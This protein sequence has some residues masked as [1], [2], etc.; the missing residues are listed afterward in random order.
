[1]ARV[2]KIVV[3]LVIFLAAF[4]ITG[5]FIIPPVLKSMLIEKMSEQLHRDVSIERIAL[6]PFRLCLT[7]T[8]FAVREKGKKGTFLS[9]RELFLDLEGMSLFKRAIV[10]DEARLD[11]PYIHLSRYKDGSYNFS[12]LLPAEKPDEKEKDTEPL[13]LSVNNIRIVDGRVTFQDEPM[14]TSHVAEKIQIG[15][16]FL[17]NISRYIDTFVEPSFSA[18]INGT[19]YN[20][21]GRTKPF[22]A[23]RLTEFDIKIKGIDIPHYL[24]YIPGKLNFR[25]V[26][27]FL[28]V[29]TKLTFSQDNE[30]GHQ[31]LLLSGGLSFSKINVDDLQQK[32]LIRIPA[33]N[34]DMASVAPLNGEIK[35]A[36]LFLDSP[37]INVHRTQDGQINLLSLLPPAEEKRRA[38]KKAQE[39]P[40][41]F[42]VD[43][44]AFQLEKGHVNYVDDIPYR[45]FQTTLADIQL[46]GDHLSTAPGREGVISL[47]LALPRNGKLSLEGPA[48][49]SPLSAKLNV[50]LQEMDIADMQPYIRD[51]LKVRVTRGK[52]STQGV[53]EL[54]KPLQELQ[55]RYG[56]KVSINRFACLDAVTASDLLKWNTLYLNGIDFAYQPLSLRIGEIALSNFY[57]RLIIREDGTI[58]LQDLSADNKKAHGGKEAPKEGNKGAQTKTPARKESAPDIRIGAVTLQGGTIDFLDKSIRPKFSA[59]LSAVGG[60]VSGLSSRENTRADVLLRGKLEG[61]APLEIKGKINPLQKDLY[62]DLQALF[63][64][65][66]LSPVTP[67]SGKYLGYEIAKGKLSFDLKYHIDRRKLDSQNII[68]IDQL[69]LGEKVDSPDATKLP[70]SLAISLLKDR[71]GQIKLDIPVAG[72]LD[73]PE[74]SVW[75]I[76]IK[77]ILNLLAKA[78]TAPFALLGS[79]FGGGEEMSYVEFDYGSAL[80]GEENLKKVALLSKALTERPALKIDLEGYVDADQDREALRNITFQRK[81]KKQKLNDLIRRSKGEI[82]LDDVTISDAE[83]ETYLRKAYKVEKFPKPR[84]FIGI[85]KKLPVSETEKLMQTHIEIKD[86]DL[87]LLAS[88]RAMAVRDAVRAAGD[89]A[90]DRIFIVETKY[91]SPPQKEKLK[92]SRV[93]FVLK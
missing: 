22:K 88:Q 34:V 81:L 56:G 18:V 47:S 89:V 3:G 46:K 2:K 92:N 58:N 39:K 14:A 30:T 65:M 38:P 8:G 40:K 23:S 49:F 62:V 90:A 59:K 52:I 93:D 79:L 74:F 57:S 6:N 87:R 16:P 75:R 41:Q 67:Y 66:E 20:I 45:T 28:D 50:D 25:V 60:R 82:K 55:I 29:D 69:N 53:L 15:L 80:L 77:V 27:A 61:H 91:L 36:K 44:D 5:F 7:V 70:V 35:L 19:P 72:T 37:L 71:H 12:D 85:P 78:A 84:N 4:T 48:A 13:R 10:I 42:V 24:A 51:A 76:V 83:Y 9:F 11:T 17:S 32:P 1:M 31:D 73:D 43:I 86:D 21:K 64:G 68:F 54:Q 33:L 26:S 63:K